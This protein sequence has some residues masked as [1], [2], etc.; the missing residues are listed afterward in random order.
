LQKSK[1][2][3]QFVQL[4]RGSAE[5]VLI[6]I[7]LSARLSKLAPTQATQTDKMTICPH[8]KR[9]YA[10]QDFRN[11][12]FDGSVLSQNQTPETD[13]MIG[14]VLAG[15]FRIVERIGQGGMG[16]VYKAVHIQMDRICAIKVLSPQAGDPESASARFRREA[17][18]SSRIDSPN[19][20]TI[21]DFGEAEPGQ[22]YLAMEYIEGES[23][24]QVLNREKSL[25]LDR[26]IDITRQIARGLSAAHA[27]GI[28]HRDLKPANIMLSRRKEGEI[29]KVL[30][31]GIAKTI[32]DDDSDTL[33][34]A[35]HLLGTPTYMSPEQV[36]GESI[37]SKSDVYSLAIIVYQLLSGALPFAG[38]NLRNLMME[39]INGEPKPLRSVAPFVS[40]K[41]AQV[42]MRGLARE[43]D[44]RIAD[45]DQFSAA[46]NSAATGDHQFN[47][48]DPTIN[49]QS[50]PILNNQPE[51]G[52]QDKAP[53]S[54]VDS[55]GDSATIVAVWQ[56][57]TSS[58]P[59]VLPAKKRFPWPM[60]L[61]PAI[62]LIVMA[63]V[64]AVGYLLY[65]KTSSTTHQ[66]DQG[67]QRLSS[68]GPAG[69]AAPGTVTAD[70]ANSHYEAG[71][72]FQ[73]E[74]YS[75]KASAEAVSKNNAAVAEY[76]KAIASRS[77]FPE[78]H[79]NLG[80]A[81][82]DLGRAPEAVDEYEIAIEQY[83]KPPAQVLTNYGMALVV[84][85]R[86]S[87]AADA[88][89]KALVLN[90]NDSDL[91]YYRGFALHYAGDKTGSQESFTQYLEKA[92]QGRYAKNARD[93]LAHRAV[94][95]MPR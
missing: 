66:T 11:C 6:A 49:S 94:P 44:H 40:E 74:A 87:D 52:H 31:F 17:K 91:H 78:A 90:P 2:N 25:P 28:V 18:M 62:L 33:T 7:R 51:S 54:S 81:L 30:D 63:G 29:V 35:G 92:P 46:L 27:L 56:P 38:D 37:D 88:F 58:P 5:C 69:G 9:S 84:V 24:V 64:V 19:A 3:D 57:G 67:S 68:A 1:A 50:E 13:P 82:Y 95:T 45:V 16:C 8:C 83:Q 21:Y 34:Q 22:F 43:P 12:P 86:F 47:I 60:L 32:T 20:V 70:S 14:Q 36:M 41:I 89:A 72:R 71:K 80:V 93:I 10:D 76:R 26:V 73:Q 42:V 4:G 59:N 75:L 55:G 39:R 85:K 61:I 79:E 53:R 77:N 15:R 23:L 48:P 65:F